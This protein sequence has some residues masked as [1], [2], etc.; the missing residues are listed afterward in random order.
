GRYKDL[1]GRWLAGEYKAVLVPPFVRKYLYATR[2]ERCEKCGWAEI[3]PTTGRAPLQID[4]IDGNSQN[5]VASNLQILCPNH[6]ALYADLLH[7][8]PET[9][10]GCT[11]EDLY[12]AEAAQ[13]SGS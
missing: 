1:V 10:R 6:H 3:H 11:A 7:G 9:Q 5:T 12:C 13:H 2:G 8:R 4:H